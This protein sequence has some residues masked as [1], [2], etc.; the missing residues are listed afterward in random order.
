MQRIDGKSLAAAIRDNVKREMSTLGIR[1]TL[2]VLLVG[3]DPASHLY[4]NLKE[5]AANEAGIATDI[6]RLPADTPD[7]KL[8]SIIASWNADETV[9][10]ILVQLPLPPG[11]DSDA[12]VAAMDPRKDADGFHPENMRATLSGVGTLFPPVHESI[13]RLIGATDVVVKSASATIIANSDTF[14]EPLA[15]LLRAGGA[16][17]DIFSPDDVKRDRVAVAD[18]VVVAVGRP[19]FLDPSMI[20]PGACVID[21][22]TNRLPDGAVVGDVDA[23]R[24]ADVPGWLSPVPGGVGP[25]T[26]ALLL[27]NVLTLAKRRRGL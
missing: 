20:K 3:E 22:G 8:K 7:E 19:K 17:V 11:H 15:H 18:I 26:V 27:K 2:A 16:N 13:L 1:P 14:A 24:F 4:V 25:L 10:A 5:K 9:D 23:A 6:R 21:V 12:L